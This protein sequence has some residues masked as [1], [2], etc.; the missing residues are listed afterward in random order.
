MMHA[1]SYFHPSSWQHQKQVN[2]FEE[3]QTTTGITSEV[4]WE[5]Q[6]A[7]IAPA[8]TDDHET[9]H[10]KSLK[11]AKK[12][13]EESSTTASAATQKKEANSSLLP[14][15]KRKLF[16]SPHWTHDDLQTPSTKKK[17]K[18]SP[19]PMSEGSITAEKGGLIL[20]R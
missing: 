7:R 15:Q 8:S 11:T 10:D 14:A 13:T 16:E 1:P 5:A 2:L 18:C 17:K 20:Q 6:Q 9:L 19:L 4:D 3:H 12:S